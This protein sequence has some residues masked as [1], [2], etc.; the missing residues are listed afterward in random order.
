MTRVRLS[1]AASITPT[2]SGVI[3]SSDLG[4]FRL[5]GADVGAFAANI[6]PLLD[7]EISRNE[8]AERLDG[9]SESSVL[10]FLTLL[11]ERGLI[12]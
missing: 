10:N 7:G 5:H 11:E 8:I 9:Y 1:P 6:Q 2:D 12:L 3:L 4:T